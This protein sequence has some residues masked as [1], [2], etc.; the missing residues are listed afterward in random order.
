MIVLGIETSCDETGL[1][2]YDAA[3]GELIG[4]ALH[5]QVDLHRVFGGVV[6]ELAARD[7]VR[8]LPGLTRVLLEEAGVTLDDL[9]GIAYTRGPGL[10]PALRVGAMFART[11]AAVNDLPALG[12]HHLE[13]HLLSPMLQPQRR[14]EFPLLVLL[15][16]GGHT[17]L[18]RAQSPGRYTL[19]GESR[20][21]AVGEA[22]DKTAQLLD[23]PYPG[24]P[25]LARLAEDGD[26]GRFALPK[27]MPQ[28][29][30]FSFSGLK[31][32]VR[33]L[34]QRLGEGAL[35]RQTRADIAASFERTVVDLLV[36]KCRS[37]LVHT[38]DERLLISGGVSANKTLRADLEKLPVDVILAEPRHCTD[39]GAMIALAGALR[40]SA[41]ECEDRTSPPPVV[42]RWPLE[43]LDGIG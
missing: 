17:Q 20:D 32:S 10:L 43:E 34:L 18:I 6:P 33:T 29:L 7:H 13:G 14:I 36:H 31:T 9:G 30:E 2:L 19:L 15:V 11:L 16:S 40:L 25:E 39:N 12:V 38:G 21:D 3:A 5:S 35:E 24:G 23:L 22:F 42:P 28:G 8:R 41:G 37:A 4:E 27:P 26:P 1:G